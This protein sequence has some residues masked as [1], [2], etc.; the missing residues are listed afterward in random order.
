MKNL[1]ICIGMMAFVISCDQKSTEISK[2]DGQALVPSDGPI[3]DDVVADEPQDPTGGIVTEAETLN[4]SSLAVLPAA[5]FANYPTE[6]FASL[7]LI[8]KVDKDTIVF[9]GPD[10]SSWVYG[11]P[12]QQE[13]V[14][15]EPAINALDGRTRY[16]M[17]GGDFWIVDS[18]RISKR[19]FTEEE[20]E[21]R[22]VMHNFDITKLSGNP[23]ALRVLGLTRTSA[24]I[25][26]ETHIG[27]FTVVDGVASA[28]EFKSE[29]PEPLTG[30]IVS[31]GQVEQGGYW[32]L[33]DAGEMAVLSLKSE[34]W[35]WTIVSLPV[36]NSQGVVKGSAIWLSLADQG[37]IGDA[38]FLTDVSIFSVSGAPVAAP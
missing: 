27:V 13:L 16:V 37:A 17:P 10:G 2:R 14:A 7:G 28:Y 5:N 18:Q 25:H 29:L 31:A 9:F 19:K 32:F 26:L 8:S 24:I 11:A 15:L 20:V 38:A 1:I 36:A 22:V 21:N 30:A 33:T 4:F 35:T 6:D 34:I 23:E 12:D 3:S